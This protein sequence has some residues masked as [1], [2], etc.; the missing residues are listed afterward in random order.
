[1]MKSFKYALEGIWHGLLFERNVRIHFIVLL[2]TIVAGFVFRI[3]HMEWIVQFL[4][5]GIVIAAELMN[6]AIENLT[7]GVYPHINGR[8]KV[9]KDVAAGS[10]LFAATMAFVIGLMIYLPKIIE[11]CRTL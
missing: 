11:L 4:L 5:F 1:M 6:T 10:V 7:D 8:A 2:L 3:S 9:V